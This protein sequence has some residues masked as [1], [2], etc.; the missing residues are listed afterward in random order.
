M[1]INKHGRMVIH[2]MDSDPDLMNCCILMN[3]IVWIQSPVLW[4]SHSHKNGAEIIEFPDLHD[5]I[6]NVFVLPYHFYSPIIW[7]YDFQKSSKTVKH[8]D[9]VG[10][11]TTPLKNMSSSVGMMRFPIYGKIIHSCSK[12]P[13]KDFRESSKFLQW[14]RGPQ[15]TPARLAAAPRRRRRPQR[16]TDRGRR[17]RPPGQQAWKWND[18]KDLWILHDIYIYMEYIYMEYIYIYVWNGIYG[19]TKWIISGI[20]G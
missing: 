15:P 13:T 16:S 11:T 17:R 4:L 19:F 20:C 3:L 6:S 2:L 1:D 5:L 12:P 10:G 8:P 14:S 18:L 7:I 9:L